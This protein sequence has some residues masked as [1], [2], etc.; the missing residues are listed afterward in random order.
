[1]LFGTA[2]F[3]TSPLGTSLQ[4][5]ALPAPFFALLRNP[6]ARR[7]YLVDTEL[8]GADVHLGCGENFDTGEFFRPGLQEAFDFR[9]SIF[10]SE[11]TDVSASL[12]V[13]NVKLQPT[14]ER[15]Q[16]ADLDDL[17]S[18]RWDGEPISI[19]LGGVDFA[20]AEFTP[21]LTGL[22]KDATWN[23]QG[24]QL[25]IR[26][27]AA[28][29]DLP[30]Q[31]NVYAGTGML[32]G[33]KNLKNREKPLCM[34]APRQVRPILLDRPNQVYQVNDGEMDGYDDVF[35]NVA[36]YTYAGDVADVYAWTPISGNYVSQNAG[37]YFRLGS[38]P[39]GTVTCN[40][41][42]DSGGPLGYVTRTADVIRRLL[43]KDAD[44]AD[45]DLELSSF[46]VVNALR[47]GTVG[48]YTGTQKLTRRVV[49]NGLLAPLGFRSFTG[50]GHLQIGLLNPN[51]GASREIF[52]HDIVAG[53]LKRERTQIPPWKIRVGHSRSFT[54]LRDSDI[55]GSATEANKDF[56][57]E[58]F[59][60]AED[61][62]SGVQTNHPLSE[63]L[64]LFSALTSEVDA[65]AEVARA[66]SLL[67]KDL[68]RYTLVTR[69]NSH[70]HQITV[71]QR[72]R[73][74]HSRF[75]L[76]GGLDLFVLEVHERSANGT[77]GLVLWG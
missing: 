9:Q 1:M 12:G 67:A 48:I 40:P 2:P 76:A 44:W 47:P 74:F 30:I 36:S 24:I 46:A 19:L 69:K 17:C 34:G 66:M 29:L 61:S 41:R 38:L 45:T 35:D 33:G 15:K 10:G 63:P 70:A 39:S 49:I 21:V 73:I 3:G 54:V 6:E 65:D 13:G 56:V 11:V 22:V 20:L 55:A 62:S 37:G 16:L 42:G 51:A 71:G 8:D 25:I 5:T 77:T 14:R 27:L 75:G 18:A 7:I 59:R 60:F 53:T 28:R 23:A 57:S 72:V 50:A 58:E 64:D 68:N 4:N 31:T 52:E 43:T 26:D 32:E